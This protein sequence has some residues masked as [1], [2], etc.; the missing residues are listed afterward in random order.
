MLP[1]RCPGMDAATPERLS[2]PTIINPSYL[3][4]M[5]LGM[6]VRSGGAILRGSLCQSRFS[7]C[8]CDL[9]PLF[10]T[11]EKNLISMIGDPCY[12]FDGIHTTQTHTPRA[13]CGV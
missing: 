8:E 10:G 13:T 6:V 4:T 1:A 7:W 5:A 2:S 11:L 3:S 9:H 12:L